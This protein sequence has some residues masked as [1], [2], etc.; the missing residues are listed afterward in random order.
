MATAQT[1]PISGLSQLLLLWRAGRD[2]PF[3]I[4]QRQIKQTLAPRI[5]DAW[6]HRQLVAMG[7]ASAGIR[8]PQLAESR[9]IC[10]V[11]SSGMIYAVVGDFGDQF[12]KAVG[13]WIG[14]NLPD[15][16]VDAMRSGANGLTVGA[17]SISFSRTELRTIVAIT[18]QTQ[19]EHLSASELRTA[20]RFSEGATYREI[21]AE[22]G[23]STATVR[24]QISAAYRKLNVHSKVELVKTLTP[25]N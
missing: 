12:S 21:A 5:F 20:Q 11:D 1:D 8:D 19:T 14:P 15:F 3:S 10:I 18:P 23:L 13:G 16:V 22:H 7:T 6:Q 9:A 25:S 4:E 2:R 17:Y 24:N